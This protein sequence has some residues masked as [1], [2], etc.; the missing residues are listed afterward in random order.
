M[1]NEPNVSS[2]NSQGWNFFVKACFAISLSAMV[3][4]IVFLPVTVWI[5]GYLGMGTLMVM[6]S[7]IML[8]KTVRDEFE[9]SKLVNRI[10]DA[11]TER[12][13]KEVDV[14]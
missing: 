7:S 3:I 10:S 9:A 14:A 12:L 4:A 8:S 11:R 13:L 6:T 2:M 1:M 5:K